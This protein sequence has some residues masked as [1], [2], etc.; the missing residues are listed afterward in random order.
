MIVRS[1]GRQ[2]PRSLLGPNHIE[3][4]RCNLP[5]VALKAPPCQNLTGWFMTLG[6]RWM[7][8]DTSV[9]FQNLQQVLQKLADAEEALAEAPRCTSLCRKRI[10]EREQEIDAYKLG[11]R[12]QKKS[13]DALNLKLTTKEA[14]IQKLQGVLNQ[15]TSNKEYDIVKG[16][17]ATA[18]GIIGKLEDQALQI[19]E[20]VDSAKLKLIE[21]ER[22]L[23]ERQAELERTIAQAAEDAPGLKASVDQ[24][25]SRLKAMEKDIPSSDSLIVLRRLRTAHGPGA[26][27]AIDEDGFCSACNNKVTTQDGVRVNMGDV[28]YCRACGRILYHC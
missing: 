14:E 11:I 25:E 21:L 15:A 2:R 5:L 9:L 27:A 28:V 7:P 6:D 4:G 22:E 16:Q 10:A 26:C 18:G 20:D 3:P 17:I 13:A 1:S 23:T 24:C 19:L 8:S 12:E